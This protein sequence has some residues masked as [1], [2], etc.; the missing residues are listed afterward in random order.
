MLHPLDRMEQPPEAK[1]DS[2]DL[3][4]HDPEAMKHPLDL[5]EHHPEATGLP[6]EATPRRR[7]PRRDPPEA[8][9]HPSDWG[10]M[11]VASARSGGDVSRGVVRSSSRLLNKPS[12]TAHSCLYRDG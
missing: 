1:K 6:P 12:N 8:A 7:H 4:G 9:A 3:M 10:G 5:I 11:G 2:L